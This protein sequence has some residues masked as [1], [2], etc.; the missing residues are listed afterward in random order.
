MEGEVTP[1]IFHRARRVRLGQGL[2]GRKLEMYT[3]THTDTH[4]AGII[5]RCAVN[6]FL[7]SVTPFSGGKQS[8]KTATKN[9]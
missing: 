2:W 5:D 7:C 9:I 6:Y 8:T 4:I 3:H 1:N